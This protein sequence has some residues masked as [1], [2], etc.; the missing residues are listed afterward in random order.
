MVGWAC[1][2]GLGFGAGYS[3]VFS[4]NSVVDC[5]LVAV[6]VLVFGGFL[7]VWLACGGGRLV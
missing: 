3:A 2:L 7:V 4:F 6:Y 5:V 1:Y